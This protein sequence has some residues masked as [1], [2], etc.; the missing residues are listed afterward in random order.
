MIFTPSPH[1]KYATN[2]NTNIDIAFGCRFGML[3]QF[4]LMIHSDTSSALEN[5]PTKMVNIIS[6]IPLLKFEIVIQSK[7]MKKR[8]R[9]LP[10]GCKKKVAN[11]TL[12]DSRVRNEMATIERKICGKLPN[13][14]ITSSQREEI[15]NPVTVDWRAA[16]YIQLVSQ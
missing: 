13:T 12:D 7:A 11:L 2:G 15:I 8:A 14:I 3:A 9:E 5:M 10:D 16:Q 6:R 1:I 4:S